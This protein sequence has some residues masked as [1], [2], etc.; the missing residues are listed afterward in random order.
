[1]ERFVHGIWGLEHGW[2]SLLDRS[3]GT[4]VDFG[5]PRARAGIGILQNP[6]LRGRC[7]LGNI[8]IHGING[9]VVEYSKI[10][11]PAAATTG[12]DD[13]EIV[14]L[15]SWTRSASTASSAIHAAT[16]AADNL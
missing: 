16:S 3:V 8:H 7:D 15:G 10:L 6:R 4:Q 5:R 12:G 11:Q 9:L 2:R 1:G 13:C 14:A